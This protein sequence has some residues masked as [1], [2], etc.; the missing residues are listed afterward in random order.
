MYQ[1]YLNNMHK[2]RLPIQTQAYIQVCHHRRLRPVAA[3][4][5][6]ALSASRHLMERTWHSRRSR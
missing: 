3:A 1:V 6:L 4:E 2:N 5:A